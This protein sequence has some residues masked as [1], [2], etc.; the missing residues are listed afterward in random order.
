MYWRI[1]RINGDGSLRIIYDGTSAHVNGE[2]SADRIA[3]TNIAWNTNSDDVKYV[4]Y[5]YGGANGEPS[6]S[7]EQAQTNETNSNIKTQLD[8]WYKENILD[9]GYRGAVSDEIFCNDRSI[10]NSSQL[11]YGK[12]NTNYGLSSRIGYEKNPKPILKCLQKNDAFTVSDK[13]KGNGALLYPVGLITTDETIIS[14]R[15][16]QLANDDGNTKYYIFKGS[17]FWT[18]S[19]SSFSN[20][21]NAYVSVLNNK[22]IPTSLSVNQLYNIAPVINLSPEYVNTMIGTGTMTDPYRAA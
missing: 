9:T 20:E 7:K 3:M 19:P 2:E 17:E 13:I 18:L 14:G 5:M 22:G 12:N 4:G 1:I 8:N 11:G 15:G 10:P 6:T 16:I 21:A